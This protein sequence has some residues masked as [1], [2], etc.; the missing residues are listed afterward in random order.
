MMF[1]IF[2]IYSELLWHFINISG[3][4]ETVWQ[5]TCSVPIKL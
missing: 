1:G 3:Y 2:N 5:E 4:G